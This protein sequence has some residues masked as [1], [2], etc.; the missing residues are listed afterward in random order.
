M[1]SRTATRGRG[2]ELRT[3]WHDL[4]SKL[5]FA[6]TVIVRN[7]RAKTHL[8]H[9]KNV[10]DVLKLRSS[11]F[12]YNSLTFFRVGIV[13][14]NP[15]GPRGQDHFYLVLDLRFAPGTEHQTA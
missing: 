5:D 10:E 8:Q 4:V 3:I 2:R 15:C 14:A 1:W 6:F 7:S 9:I 12:A 11:I 13:E